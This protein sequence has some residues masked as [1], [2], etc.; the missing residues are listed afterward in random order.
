M[1]EFG[2]SR[3]GQILSGLGR[4][5]GLFG[6]S[7]KSGYLRA[8]EG[9]RS[10]LLETGEGVVNYIEDSRSWLSTFVGLFRRFYAGGLLP[11][12]KW[13]R[14]KF[15]ALQAWLKSV[16]KPLFDF[17]LR[18]RRELLHFYTRFVRPVLDVI[19]AVRFG[20]QLLGRLGVEWAQELDRKLET[21]AASIDSRFRQVL[22]KL[23]SALD[24]LDT[25]IDPIG[26]LRRIPLLQSLNRDAG[27]W[28]RIWWNKQITPASSH[29]IPPRIGDKYRRRPVQQDF[30]EMSI[31]MRTGGGP[32]GPRVDE[33][34]LLTLA[35][36]RDGGSGKPDD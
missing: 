2:E 15:L 27:Y 33:Y 4:L 30:D 1:A 31:F 36:M 14:D 18:I 11:L 17:L 16:F 35:F 34:L 23:N 13:L 28:I 5:V 20:L 25:I 21:I 26:L 29:P 19:E 9:L 3:I 8:F 7:A 32:I 12:L 22:G 24:F 10:A 6:G